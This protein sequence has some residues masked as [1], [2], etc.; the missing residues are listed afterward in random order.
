MKV[1]CKARRVG[2]ILIYHLLIFFARLL[3]S[4]INALPR[5]RELMNKINPTIKKLVNKNFDCFSCAD[6]NNCR[7]GNGEDFGCADEAADGMQ[8]AFNYLAEI[9]RNEAMKEIIKVIKS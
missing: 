9:P 6:Y 8:I 1:L 7:F 3:I 2:K 5:E 4:L